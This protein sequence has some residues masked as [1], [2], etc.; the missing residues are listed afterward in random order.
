VLERGKVAETGDHHTLLA[1]GGPYR[2]LV[3]R[4]LESAA[5]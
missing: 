3:S 5:E 2:Q 4:R 1:Q